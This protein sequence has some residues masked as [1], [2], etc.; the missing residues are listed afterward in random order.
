MSAETMKKLES[1]INKELKK[2]DSWLIVNRLSLNIDEIT[3]LVFHPYNKPIKQRITL[4][5]HK[6]AMS[7]SEYKKYLGIMGDSTLRWNIHIDEI[8]RTISTII[9]LYIFLHS[10]HLKF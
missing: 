2:L 4:K 3:F 10:I 7:E 5:I 9:Q 1:V 8:S 6:K